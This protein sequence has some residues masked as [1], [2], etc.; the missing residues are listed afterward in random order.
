M[1]FDAESIISEHIAD[2]EN[3]IELLKNADNSVNF[4]RFIA[5]KEVDIS[6]IKEKFPYIN[7]DGNA[8]TDYEGLLYFFSDESYK[9]SKELWLGENVINILSHIYIDNDKENNIK[10][11]FEQLGFSTFNTESFITSIVSG[12][13]DFKDSVN[14][15]I[16]D[17][18][19]KSVSLVKYLFFARE[20]I[21]E[22]T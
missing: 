4:F 21:K 18:F 7:E 5:Q 11:L 8:I 9:A 3:A 19:D 20:T 10:P 15:A 14:D 12:D 22:K 6:D 1:D 2:N 13:S 16:S 17:N